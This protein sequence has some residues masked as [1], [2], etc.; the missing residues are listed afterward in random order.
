MRREVHFR[1]FNLMITCFRSKAVSGDLLSQ[2]DDHFDVATRAGLANRL[3]GCQPREGPC[4]WDRPRPF[5]VNPVLSTFGQ[6]SIGARVDSTAHE[7]QPQ[8]PGDG[9]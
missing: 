4:L 6:P 1:K 2:R 5:T 3:A 8:D 9:H 7:D